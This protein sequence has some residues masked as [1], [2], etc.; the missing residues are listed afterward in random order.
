MKENNRISKFLIATFFLT[1]ILATIIS[2][3]YFLAFSNNLALSTNQEVW[4]WFG[5]YLGGVLSPI[6]AFSA[7]FPVLMRAS[8]DKD[9]NCYFHL[10]L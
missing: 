1:L 8:C 7:L 4:A 9:C 3:K 6:F 5:D 10:H 2:Y